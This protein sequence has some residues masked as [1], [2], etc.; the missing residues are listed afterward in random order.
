MEYVT[1]QDGMLQDGM[2]FYK[3]E[4]NVTGHNGM[5]QDRMGCYR[6]GCYNSNGM[7]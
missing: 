3:T 4:W 6:T 5:L 7:G 1:G 2:G